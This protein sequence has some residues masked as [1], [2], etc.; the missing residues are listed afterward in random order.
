MRNLAC[1]SLGAA[2][3]LALSFAAFAGETCGT[4]TPV[5][6]G[7]TLITAGAS[8]DNN[9]GAS[10]NGF[11]AFDVFFTFTPATTGK[12]T[13]DTCGSTAS[14]WFDTVLSVY[15][16]T[17]GATVQ[18][19]CSDDNGDTACG[20][21]GWS[22]RVTNLC[23]NAG[24]TYLI[25]VAAYDEFSAGDGNGRLTITASGT[26][27]VAPAND[28][29]TNAQNVGVGAFPFDN[30]GAGT[31]GPDATCGFAGN[32]GTHDIFFR[33]TAPAD[34]LYQFD[35]CATPAGGL[36]DTILQLID[37]CGGSQIAC[38]DDGCG[39]IGLNSTVQ[40]SMT[41]GQQV[42]VRLSSWDPADEN[43]GVLTIGAFSQPLEI[44]GGFS[45]APELTQVFVGAFVTPGSPPPSTGLVVTA[46]LSSIGGSATQ[47]LYDSG[48]PEDEIAG[49]NVYEFLYTLPMSAVAGTY[50]YPIA[51]H[52]DQGRSASSS[53]E[54]T[55]TNGPSGACCAG[56]GA[57]DIS[58]ETLCAPSGGTWLGAGTSCG[59]EGYAVSP[60]GVGND[61]LSIAATGNLLGTI[62]N[63]DDCTENIPMP[64]PFSF[65]G[66]PVTNV[67]VSSNGNVQFDAAFPDAAYT[68]TTIPDGATPSN[69]IYP[70]WDDYNPGAGGDVYYQVFGSSPNQVLKISWE[71]VTEF[72]ATN[73]NNFQITF[74][75]GSN[76]FIVQ[77]GNM[78]NLP[79]AFT[80]D[81]T[82]GV[83]NATDTS[84]TQ[85]PT[86][87]ADDNTEFEWNTVTI[88][89]PCGATCDSVDFNNDTL[90]P[91]TADIDDFLS[92][93]SGGPCSTGACGDIDFNNDTLYP[94]TLDIDSL[95][96][97]FSGG[98]CL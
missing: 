36:D 87:S 29:C 57:C 77:Y 54:V 62:S 39:P 11:S 55:I 95:L 89:S 12:Y 78:D 90:F 13:F 84:A 69:A 9:P 48:P 70:A 47:T 65:Y 1:T 97:V 91:D 17:C 38:G 7:T 20:P 22:S 24:Q 23:M 37:S 40:L 66:T 41:A 26:C 81:V 5:G 92:V 63:C 94:D 72:G 21:N 14:Q 96:S 75:E 93:F 8:T 45:T 60:A 18:M 33:F 6:L 98:P 58:R 64:F 59:G 43:S 15:S 76:S 67:A 74:F 51:V 34:D 16:G 52:D 31:E 80:G 73:N 3:A 42:L 30:T 85:Q 68:N 88:P 46:D 25:R 32:T 44:A 83:E 49:D 71:G 35:T 19:G 27:G 28:L 79:E 56:G 86:A 10:C 82:I 50:N 2:A 53:S 4:A 61:F